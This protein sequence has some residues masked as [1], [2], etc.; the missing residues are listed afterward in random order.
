MTAAEDQPLEPIP[1]MP[2]EEVRRRLLDAA[3]RIFAERGYADSRLEDIAHAAGFTKGALYSNFG[4]KQDLFG[5]ILSERA[6]TEL[7]TVMVET[8]D[9]GD[10]S[11]MAARVA[12]LVA[13]RIVED[14]ARGRLGLEFAARAA[15]DEQARSVVTPMRRAQREAAS[16]AIVEVTTR[17][18]GSPPV[19][20][21]LAALILHCLTNGLSMEHLADPEAISAD[22]AE[23]ALSAVLQWLTAGAP[24]N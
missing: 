7:A 4:G 24:E 12:H 13:Q 9:I 14:T 8:E 5:A 15:R 3:A 22:V 16:R 21:D 17:C 18:G 19:G 2:R 1:R 6:H 20:P 10:A 11:A 23:R